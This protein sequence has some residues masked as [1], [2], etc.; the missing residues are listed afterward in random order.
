MA[1][2]E[3]RYTFAEVVDI[4][5]DYAVLS[6]KRKRNDSISL[7]WYEGILG[8]WPEL[9]LVKPRAPEGK[10][11]KQGDCLSVFHGVKLNYMEV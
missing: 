6:G 2:F 9:K 1:S 3:Y 10:N 4:A 8:R 5:L 7:R 11:G